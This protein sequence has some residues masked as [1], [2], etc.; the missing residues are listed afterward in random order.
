MRFAD[1]PLDCLPGL[2][3]RSQQQLAALGITRVA[4]LHRLGQ[5]SGNKQALSQRLGVPQRYISKWL[6]L[7]DLARVPSVGCTYNGL[8]LHVGIASVAQ[9]ATASVVS[10]YP[11][12]RR[13]HSKLLG[14][15]AQCPSQDQVVQW[16][17]EARQL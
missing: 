5:T 12:L 2:D 13:L 15:A 1:L 17:Q 16:I 11:K 10:L 9:L 14:N 6:A 7:A 8:L 3:T 4:Q